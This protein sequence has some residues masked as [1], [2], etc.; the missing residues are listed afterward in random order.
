[1]TRQAPSRDSFGQFVMGLVVIFIFM[2]LSPGLPAR[3]SVRAPV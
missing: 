3:D 1:M 2:F